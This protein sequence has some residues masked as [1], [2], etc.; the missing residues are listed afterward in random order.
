MLARNARG[1]HARD[2]EMKRIL[3]PSAAFVRAAKRLAKKNPEAAAGLNATL[4]AMAD[5]VSQAELKT[6][7]LKGDLAGSLACR[8]AYDLR[9]I[10]EFI[11][12][13]GVE[14]IFLLSVGTHDEIY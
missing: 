10:F 8:A 7:K 1:N 5:D 13:D 9:V 4:E 14:A 6:H 12:R 3:I 2:F 11:E